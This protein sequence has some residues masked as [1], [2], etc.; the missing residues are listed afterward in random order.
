VD[1]QPDGAAGIGQAAADRLTDPQ[2]PVGGELEALSPVE[3]LDGADQ[4]EHALLDEVAEGEALALVLAGH[5]DHQTEVGVDHA[6][7]GRQIA[8]LDALGELDLLLCGEQG[9]TT[10]LVEEELEGVSRY[11][12]D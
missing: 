11:F 6:V 10:R 3:L 5:R 12:W 2:G 7:L 4:A 8:L 1:G 9:V